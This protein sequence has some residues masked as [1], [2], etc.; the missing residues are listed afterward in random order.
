MEILR[1]HEVP[2]GI[3]ATI[4]KHNIHNAE[5]LYSFCKQQAVSLKLSPLYHSGQATIN[6]ES[7]AISI[8]EYTK[9][10]KQLA[11][12]WL[13]DEEPITIDP[14]EPLLVNTLGGSVPTV[15]SFSSNC[16]HH[17]LGIGPTGDLYPCG[18]FQGYSEF[19]YGNIL[20]T[21]LKDIYSSSV[22]KR[23]EGRS[24]T[25]LEKCGAC[26]IYEHCHGGCPFHAMVNTG[27]L[28]ERTPLCQP[29]KQ[30]VATIV[31]ELSSRLEQI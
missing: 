11:K 7:L 21:H 22:F 8:D 19:S 27:S 31:D 16:H 17:F 18:L 15:C 30:S 20:T 12:L 3:L 2:F 13:E 29:Y 23:L 5:E 10:T 28:Y 9:F 25:I 1:R 14:I 26:S 6:I 24:E 4:A